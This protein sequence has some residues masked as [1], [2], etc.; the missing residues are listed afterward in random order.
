MLARMF[1]LVKWPSL[2]PSSRVIPPLP[3]VD[4][5]GW[6]PWGFLPHHS[7]DWERFSPHGLRDSCRKRDRCDPIKWCCHRTW[8]LVQPLQV[9]ARTQVASRSGSV[10]WSGR[11]SGLRWWAANNRTRSASTPSRNRPLRRRPHCQRGQPDRL[12]FPQRPPGRIRRPI[13]SW[14]PSCPRVRSLGS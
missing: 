10:A 4:L 7:N 11:V 5:H 13:A 3:P 2:G 9:N 1:K 8:C 12:R 6:V 14:E